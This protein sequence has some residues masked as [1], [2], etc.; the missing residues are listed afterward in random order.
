MVSNVN[1]SFVDRPYQMDLDTFRSVTQIQAFTMFLAV[2]SVGYF[3][4]QSR[5]L[6]TKKLLCYADNNLISSNEHSCGAVDAQR[7][8]RS[9]SE[10]KYY[11]CLQ[12]VSPGVVSELC[13]P[14]VTN[15]TFIRLNQAL[16]DLLSH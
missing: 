12:D 6:T 5:H 15:M 4:G 16:T 11:L 1:A 8:S 10:S 3:T 9:V 13:V 2:F 7:I 14:C